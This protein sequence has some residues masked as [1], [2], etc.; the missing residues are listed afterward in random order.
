MDYDFEVEHRA[1]DKTDHVDAL[2]RNPNA[3][4]ESI[5]E[6]TEIF[7]VLLNTMD[8][9]D[10][11]TLAQRHDNKL[12]EIIRIV[13]LGGEKVLS[14]AEKKFKKS[15]VLL[16]ENY[17]VGTVINFYGYYQNEQGVK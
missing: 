17:I 5:L 7:H 6:E 15:I 11:L 3:K 16:M 1:G 13:G 12:N 4:E 9:D 2:L 14:K 10:W 8:S